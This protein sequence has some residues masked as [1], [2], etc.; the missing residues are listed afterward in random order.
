MCE[1]AG[2]T[3]HIYQC[4]TDDDV[5][6]VAADA[7]ALLVQYAPITA[8]VVSRLERCKVIVRY[9]IGVDGVDLTAAER[10]GIPVCNVPDYGIGRGRR[11]HRG[12][13]PRPGAAIARLRPGRPPRGLAGDAAGTA[14][15]IAGKGPSPSSGPAASAG[16]CSSGRTASDSVWRARDPFV[17]AADLQA[18]GAAAVSLDDA[19]VQADILSL[20]LPLTAATRHLVDRDPPEIHAARR[21]P[22][23]HL[24]RRPRRHPGPGRRPCRGRHRPGRPRRLRARAP[25]ARPPPARVPE[26]PADAP[27]GLLQRGP[28]SSACSAG[29]P[30]RSSAPWPAGPCAAPVRAIP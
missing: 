5:I 1:R 27:H 28:A 21:H 6:A 19:F 4:R 12:P 23:Q 10:H 17:A 13:G 25:R 8:A 26:R 15:A 30:K 11:P 24:A 2:H 3:L 7:D 16:R 9:G 29:R 20:H 22:D 14:P 18:L